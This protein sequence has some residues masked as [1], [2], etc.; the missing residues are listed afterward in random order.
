MQV[1][2]V[3]STFSLFVSNIDKKIRAFFSKAFDVIDEF[4]TDYQFIMLTYGEPLKEFIETSVIKI[5]AFSKTPQGQLVL[6]AASVSNP[7]LAMLISAY[8]TQFVPIVEAHRGKTLNA[9]T[10]DMLVQEVTK[11]VAKY[12][13]KRNESSDWEQAIE[14]E[15]QARIQASTK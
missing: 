12:V 4:L 6:A 2:I 10:Q 9:T 14:A 5:E 8:Q 11:Q 13:Q 15:L 7:K 3:M 1:V